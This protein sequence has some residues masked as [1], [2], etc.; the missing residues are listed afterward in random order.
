MKIKEV[1]DFNLGDCIEQV[2]NLSKDTIFE[3]DLTPN[4]G[5]CFSHLGVARELA[6]FAKQKINSF[7]QHPRNLFDQSSST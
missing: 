7:N 4:R 3:I 1:K 5:D 6:V 2:L